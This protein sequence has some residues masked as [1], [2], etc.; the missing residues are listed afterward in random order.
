MYG[1]NRR[2]PLFPDA[3]MIWNRHFSP[4]GQK[5]YFT[6]NRPLQGSDST[7]DYDIWYL[8][9]KGD[10]WRGPFNAGTKIN[11]GKDEFYPSQARNGNL[12]FT[13]DNGETKR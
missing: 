6:S 9:K 3:S 1:Q 8:L 13:R 7:K 4:D 10:D 5:L 2:L 11:T 12:Y